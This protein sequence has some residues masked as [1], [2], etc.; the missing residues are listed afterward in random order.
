MRV[1]AALLAWLLAASSSHALPASNSDLAPS[2]PSPAT[3]RDIFTETELYCLTLGIYFEG[4][5]TGEP[6]IGQRH[7]ARVIMERAKA[8]RP[9]WGGKT[10]CG[11][12]FYKRKIC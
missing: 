2:R 1:A 6:E 8:D 7:I 4:G 11:V 9:Y 12:V 10:I 5:S 3:S